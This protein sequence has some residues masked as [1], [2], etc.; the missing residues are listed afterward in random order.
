M[1]KGNVLK[2]RCSDGRSRKPDEIRGDFIHQIRLPG[3][4]LFPD[5][6]AQ[7]FKNRWKR[8]VVSKLLRRVQMFAIEVMVNLKSPK[9]IY[10]MS[11]NH[12]GAAE[13]IGVSDAQARRAHK[14]FAQ[15]LQ[16]RFP[17]IPVIALHDLHSECG[18]YHN[19]HDVLFETVETA[20]AA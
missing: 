17:H 4:I 5:L 13:A 19:G 20:E 8:A 12:C 14:E 2:I 9:K 6:C 11:H 7:Q 18:E 1:G 3:G 15:E 16:N 10:V